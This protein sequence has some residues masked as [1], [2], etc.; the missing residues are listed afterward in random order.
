MDELQ[1]QYDNEAKKEYLRSYQKALRR[2]QDILEEIQQ[3]RMDKMFPSLVSDGMPRGSSQSDLSDYA[4]RWDEMMERL[5]EERAEKMKLMDEID[6]RIRAMKDEDEQRVLRLRYI[7]GLK[8]EEV[9][10]EMGYSWRKVHNVHG[11]AL[12]NFQLLKRA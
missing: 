8:W 3:L 5:K 12:K 4:V 2:E 7:K 6:K 10:D 1:T 9:A 11:D